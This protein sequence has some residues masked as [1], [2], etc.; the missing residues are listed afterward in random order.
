MSKAVKQLVSDMY[1]EEFGRIR[2]ACVV[3]VTRL[4]VNSVVRLRAGFRSRGVRF[5]VVK[6][7]LARR[8]LKGT[9]LEP[10]GDALAGPCCLV[11]GGDSIIEV[12]K[13]LVDAAREF[14]K[15]ELKHGIIDGDPNLVPVIALA[16]M[17]G[18]REVLGEI[19]MLISS[20][21]RALAGCLRSPAG[22]IAGC[23]KTLAE[24]EPEGGEAAGGEAS[25]GATSGGEAPVASA[26]AADA[27][28]AVQ[29]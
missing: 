8:A 9:A 15:L 27:G 12:A 5:R 11:T 16:K 13:A 22:R 14:D 24:R 4:D 20:P 2:D 17:K 10:I 18:R 21:G 19:A 1:T 23:L 25:V 6:N 26:P 7:S 3:D 29:G 28:A